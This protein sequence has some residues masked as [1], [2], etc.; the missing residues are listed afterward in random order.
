MVS[1]RKSGR[2]FRCAY[3][4]LPRGPVG[5]AVRARAGA[6]PPQPPERERQCRHPIPAHSTRR[7]SAKRGSVAERESGWWCEE[8][9]FHVWCQGAL[10]LVAAGHAPRHARSRW[11]GRRL[12]YRDRHPAERGVIRARVG[13][14]HPSERLC[15][16]VVGPGMCATKDAKRGRRAVA[17]GSPSRHR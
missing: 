15:G 13:L 14:S 17:A 9:M 16:D 3:V 4:W 11:D 8:R 1:V 6:D 7:V 5:L 12:D 10:P 2:F